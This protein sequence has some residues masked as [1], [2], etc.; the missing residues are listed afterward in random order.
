MCTVFWDTLACT[1]QVLVTQVFPAFHFAL[2]RAMPACKRPASCDEGAAPAVA[3]DGDE[4]VVAPSSQELPEAPKVEAV[5]K[6]KPRAKSKAK[7]KA[8]GKAKAVFKKPAGSSKPTSG[9]PEP[10]KK[11]G[12]KQQTAQWSSTVDN[13]EAAEDQEEEE[14]GEN[15]V[16][17]GRDYAKA[18]KFARLQKENKLPEEVKK[19]LAQAENHPNP[20]QYKS[21]L[22][23]RLFS[24]TDSGNFV[25]ATNTPTWT[26]WKSSVDTKWG[27]AESVG[28]ATSIML[29]QTFHGNQAAMDAAEAKGDIYQKGGLWFFVTVKS[30]R[31][32]TSTDQH[33]LSGGEAKLD[34]QD[35]QDLSNFMDSKKWQDFGKE[36]Q[37][38]CRPSEDGDLALPASSSRLAIED[39][40]ETILVKWEQV[41]K[42]INEAKQAQERLLR[43]GQKHTE[44]V[45]ASKDPNLEQQLKSAIVLLQEN[46]NKCTNCQLWK[47]SSQ[48]YS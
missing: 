20:R 1:L 17:E 23:N 27:S 6:P 28:V 32:K 29:W 4:T 35:Y 14:E 37:A 13:L 41:E 22:I 26:S 18:R 39:A 8:K 47:D 43:E 48:S 24:K 10:K 36:A 42:S 40:K 2:V 3:L 46:L 25:L 11:V 21:Q 34:L 9:D 31:G 38:E 33:Q 45:K 5:E 16:G 7:A 15:L 12:L 44:K 19:L 30:G